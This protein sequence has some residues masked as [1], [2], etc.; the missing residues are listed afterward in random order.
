MYRSDTVALIER[1]RALEA[2]LEDVRRQES[3]RRRRALKVIEDVAVITPCRESWRRMVRDARDARIRHCTHCRKDVYDL[4]AF[5]A[6]EVE[7][8]LQRGGD[9]CGRLHRRFDGTIVTADCPPPPGKADCKA[10]IIL[11]MCLLLLAALGVLHLLGRRQTT[12]GMLEDRT[13]HLEPS[14]P[15]IPEA[16]ADLR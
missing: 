1:R 12:F 16:G 11:R 7:S 2:E 13:R 5:D 3:E 10:I 6:L 4:S 8:L 14:R 9:L 15:P